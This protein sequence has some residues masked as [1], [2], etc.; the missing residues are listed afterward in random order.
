M[1]GEN[2]RYRRSLIVLSVDALGVPNRKPWVSRYKIPGKLPIRGLHL[3]EVKQSDT[4]Y[5]LG[6]RF[7]GNSRIWWVLTFYNVIIDPFEF[8]QRGVK[9]FV[10]TRNIVYFDVLEVDEPAFLGV[11]A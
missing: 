11:V 10:P 8:L 9:L 2:S 4:W 3:Y 6:A 1:I 7:F 5:T